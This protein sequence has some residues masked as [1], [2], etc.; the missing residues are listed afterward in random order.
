[1]E[2]G[3]TTYDTKIRYNYEVLFFFLL[4]KAFTH[5]IIGLGSGAFNS[6]RLYIYITFL[7]KRIHR[8]YM[9][10]ITAIS[11]IKDCLRRP[12]FETSTAK[13]NI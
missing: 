2:H 11:K 6:D 4:L 8:H 9:Q 13:I 3:Y 1:M 5:F 12:Y 7:T 10:P